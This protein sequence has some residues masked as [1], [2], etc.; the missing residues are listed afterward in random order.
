[1]IDIPSLRIGSLILAIRNGCETIE[2]I[3]Q[4]ERRY[5]DIY[6]LNDIKI[7]A[8]HID[9]YFRPVFLDQEKLMKCGFKTGFK[10]YNIYNAADADKKFHI[11]IRP[12]RFDST[13]ASLNIYFQDGFWV[14]GL[15]EYR[16]FKIQALHELQHIYFS[17]TGE[18]LIYKY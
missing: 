2:P 7:R 8:D 10:D 9:A 6:L 11:D 14:I 13:L 15:G 16:L 3:Y 4:I 17:L 12:Y 1:M 18:E 5:D